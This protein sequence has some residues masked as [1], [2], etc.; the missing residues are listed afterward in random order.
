MAQTTEITEIII[1]GG[2]PAGLAAA[3]VLARAGIQVVLCEQ[4]SYPVDKV[5]GEGL[6]PTGVHHLRQLGVDLAA[7]FPLAGVR[8]QSPDGCVAAGR[9]AQGPGAGIRRTALS[10]A[11]LAAAR[12][13]ATLSIRENSRVQLEEAGPAGVTVRVA[14]ERLRARLLIGADGLHSAVR[15]WADLERPGR[16]HWR[17]GVRQH[18]RMAP[19][20][21]SVE[22]YWS[23]RGLEA[24]VTPVAVNEVGVAFLWHRHSPAVEPGPSLVPALLA[25]FPQLARRLQHAG[26]VTE[27]RAIGPLQ[28]RTAA[29]VAEGILLLGDAAGYLDAITG[30]GLSLAFAQALALEE[31]VVPVL[32]ATTGPVSRPSLA[33]Y[34]KMHDAIVR[35]GTQVTELAL[36]LSRSPRLCNWI[37]HALHRDGALFQQLLAANMGVRSPWRADT[38]LRMAAGLLCTLPALRQPLAPSLRSS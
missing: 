6:M 10:Q 20:S 5:C 21:D 35:P 17:W 23:G 11:M 37:V 14:G 9:F 22:V 36:L 30:E 2:G 7:A 28:Q 13:H 19:W 26:P 33:A 1:V 4:R 24:Y 29:V 8:Y 34:Q 31:T 32:R 27:A 25:A 3:I 38:L 18:Y 15:R 16:R 12:Q